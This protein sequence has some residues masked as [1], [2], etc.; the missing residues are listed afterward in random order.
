M[1]KA[2]DPRERTGALPKGSVRSG[3]IGPL[4]S[5]RES[6]VMRASSARVCDGC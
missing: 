6:L 3:V 1:R 2:S 4:L 5:T